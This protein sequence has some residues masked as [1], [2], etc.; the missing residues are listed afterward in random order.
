MT[1]IKIADRGIGPDSAPFVIAEMSGNH[2]QSL[3]RAI[4]LV[5]AAAASGAHGLKIQTYTAD[6]MTLDVADGDFYI[7]DEKSLWHGQ[8]LHK[9]Y[10]QAYTPRE[11]HEPI[12]RRARE[13]GM[14]AFSTPFDETAVDFLETLDVPCYKIASCD[15]WPARG[16]HSS[17]PPAWQRWL[18]WTRWWLSFAPLAVASLCC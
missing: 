15:T 13:L 10:Q 16:D 9:L 6:T 14:V 5:E 7:S 8:S 18:N 17:S 12:F 4:K 1:A 2:N 11:W 3:D